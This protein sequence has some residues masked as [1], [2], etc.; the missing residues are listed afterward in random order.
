MKELNNYSHFMIVA[1]AALDTYKCRYTP[2]DALFC[3]K[4]AENSCH[5]AGEQAVIACLIC[6][7][8]DTRADRAG[9]DEAAR[10][11]LAELIS[12]FMPPVTET[13]VEEN[14][15]VVFHDERIPYIIRSVY[16]K[17]ACLQ[18]C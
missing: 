7:H 1:A 18:F 11:K 9:E 10:A 6:A 12:V 14:F 3:L 8:I 15:D 5:S 16:G 4:E 17:E 13:D 2:E